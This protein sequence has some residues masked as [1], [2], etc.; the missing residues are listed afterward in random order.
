MTKVSPEEKKCKLEHDLVC[1]GRCVISVA[2]FARKVSPEEKKCKLE[3]DL[4]CCGRCVI[5]VALFAR[6]LAPQVKLRFSQ[7]RSSRQSPPMPPRAMKQQQPQQV[8]RG[9]KLPRLRPKPSLLLTHRL[10]K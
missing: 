9:A 3:H 6:L 10:L 2:L 8:Q 1:C 7:P 5:S 4:V